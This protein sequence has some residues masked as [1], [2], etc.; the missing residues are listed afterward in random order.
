M[1]R[2]GQVG[3]ARML[4]LLGCFEESASSASLKQGTKRKR[5]E[6]EEVLEVSTSVMHNGAEE[7]VNDHNGLM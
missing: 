5:E 4:L 1:K 3:D 6:M 7:N 2:L